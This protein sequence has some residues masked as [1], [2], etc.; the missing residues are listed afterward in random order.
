MQSYKFYLSVLAP[1]YIIGTLKMHMVSP[2]IVF[3]YPLHHAKLQVLLV[4]TCMSNP[5][6]F[7]WYSSMH[8]V[9]PQIV[10]TTWCHHA[11]LQVFT[12]LY[13]HVNAKLHYWYSQNAHGVTANSLYLFSSPC[14]ATNLTTWCHR[15]QSLLILFTMQSYKSY[16]SSVTM[17][18][19]KFSLVCTSPCKATVH[20]W[21]SQNAHGVTA[22]SLYLSSSPCKATN[23]T[24]WCH[25]KQSLLG[26][27]QNA[28]GVTA[29]LY[30]PGVTMQSYK[31]LLVCTCM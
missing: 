19:Y 26:T 27:L 21:Y 24:T 9:S 2:Q 16:L 5:Q 8:M 28:H 10:F 13:L 17:Q 30:L 12:C 14:K 23:L 4:C 29:N 6:Y 22:N 11:K 7:T 15:K 20:Y 18:S 1:Q 3:T 31:S 25:R